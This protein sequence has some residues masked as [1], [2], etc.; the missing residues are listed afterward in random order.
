MERLQIINIDEIEKLEEWK[1]YSR[2]SISLH[3]AA[4]SLSRVWVDYGHPQ[5]D[6]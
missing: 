3:A 4:I 2:L 6:L 5:I 1:V